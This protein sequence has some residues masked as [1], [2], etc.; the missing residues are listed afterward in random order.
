MSA[1]QLALRTVTATRIAM[2][3]SNHVM[4]LDW[5]HTQ[6][7]FGVTTYAKLYQRN[8]NEGLVFENHFRHV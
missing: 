2:A 5:K 3:V 6:I 7:S 4:I 8:G 1:Y